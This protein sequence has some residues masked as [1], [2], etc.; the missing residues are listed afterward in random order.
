M[1]G[2][3]LAVTCA[4]CGGPLEHVAGGKPVAGTEAQAI[5]RCTACGRRWQVRT[6]LRQVTSEKETAR[7]AAHRQRQ[8][9]AA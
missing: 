5:A 3:Q 7:R 2:Y 6:F 4:Y 1:I 8:R 9:S